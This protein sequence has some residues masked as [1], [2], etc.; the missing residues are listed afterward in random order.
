M[1]KVI[2]FD[3]G[4]VYLTDCWGK[5]IR[6]WIALQQK[7]SVQSVEKK[8]AVM[9]DHISEGKVSEED[10]ISLFVGNNLKSIAQV[11]HQIRIRNRILHPSLRP[12][13][14][15]LRKKYTVV[16]MNNEGQAWNEYRLQRFHLH[17]I[18]DEIL[19]SYTLR[20]AKPQRRYYVKVL[21]KLHVKPNELLFIDDT[22]KNVLAARSLGINAILFKNPEQLVRELHR[23]CIV[24]S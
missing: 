2:G 21:E 7:V 24:L 4:G 23:L 16:L 20:S 15:H 12:L 18:F 5:E 11:K 13:L 1:I 22:E 6:R 14:R 17:K 8:N 9:V 3:L 19:T 10:F